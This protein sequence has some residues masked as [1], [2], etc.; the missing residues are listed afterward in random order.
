M[1]RIPYRDDKNDWKSEAAIMMY[2][3]IRMQFVESK[4]LMTSYLILRTKIGK[5]DIRAIRAHFSYPLKL[6]EYY[7]WITNG[8]ISK[9]MRLKRSRAGSAAKALERQ[10]NY[11]SGSK[12]D[13]DSDGFV[14]C[15]AHLATKFRDAVLNQLIFEA[16]ETWEECMSAYELRHELLKFSR[17]GDVLVLHTVLAENEGESVKRSYQRVQRLIYPDFPPYRRAQ[18]VKRLRKRSKKEFKGCSVWLRFRVKVRQA[19]EQA[20]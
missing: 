5:R 4:D 16:Y 15:T 19:L 13:S 12:S 3:T 11:V 18:K 17:L 14:L 6:F 2:D 7:C 10:L 9:E 8:L 1:T 20:I